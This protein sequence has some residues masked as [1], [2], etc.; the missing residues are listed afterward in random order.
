M[1]WDDVSY[2]CVRDEEGNRWFASIN[3]PNGVVRNR[4]RL[5]V[6]TV[7]IVEVTDTPSP[8]DP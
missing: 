3:V 2:V 1:A 7:Q 8:V 6:A 4:R 5:Y